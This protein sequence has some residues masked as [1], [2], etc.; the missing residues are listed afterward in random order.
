V[1]VALIAIG[2][3]CVVMVF[4]HIGFASLAEDRVRASGKPLR[5][6][7]GRVWMFSIPFGFGF[8]F[9]GFAVNR[10][11]FYE[12]GG[13]FFLVGVA[14]QLVVNGLLMRD[15]IKMKKMKDDQRQK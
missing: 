1:I 10:P 7:I 3:L 12:I 9:F 4:R 15:A 11:V 13:V 6:A 8:L 5:S 14:A 2:I